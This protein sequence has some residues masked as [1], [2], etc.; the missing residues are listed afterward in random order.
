MA[1]F[2]TT[3]RSRGSAKAAAAAASS[4]PLA[5]S[6]LASR[7]SSSSA[8]AYR[9]ARLP[10][11]MR[12]SLI[13]RTRART[14]PG[15]QESRLRAPAGSP[16]G[17]P[18]PRPPR[19]RRGEPPEPPGRRPAGRRHGC[20]RR[21]PVPA[22]AGSP[23][24]LPR[25]RGGRPSGGHAAPAG[26]EIAVERSAQLVRFLPGP[27]S[28]LE[29]GTQSLGAI[30]EVLAD[31]TREEAHRHPGEDGEVDCREEKVTDPRVVPAV[32]HLRPPVP[33]PRARPR[34]RW[35]RPRR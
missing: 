33:P 19:G 27:R 23:E 1:G 21:P 34:A 32:L 17:S 4:L 29:L 7:A 28:S 16:G 25:S 24:P 35:Y 8:R 14:A 6:V 13:R 12:A 31:G 30:A 20:A 26:R 2:S 5:S 11:M 10:L 15:R 18:L 22:R 3:A 9:R